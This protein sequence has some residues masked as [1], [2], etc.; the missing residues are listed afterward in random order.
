MILQAGNSPVSTFSS[1]S[2]A[3]DGKDDPFSGRD[4]FAATNGDRDPF[5]EDPFKGGGMDDPFNGSEYTMVYVPFEIHF[6]N[7]E[8]N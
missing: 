4:P 6:N 3:E 2:G 1:M 7:I 8:V 5:G